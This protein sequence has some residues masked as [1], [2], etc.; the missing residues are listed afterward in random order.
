MARWLHKIRVMPFWFH[1]TEKQQ[2]ELYAIGRTV[3][4]HKKPITNCDGIIK[5]SK[6]QRWLA[7]DFVI[8]I[9]GELQWSRIP[10]YEKFGKLA[11]RLGL[12][13]GGDW[14]SDDII[15]P[16]ENDVYHVEHKGD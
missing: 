9:D 11:K 4:T 1:R 6:H 10:A 5:I 8:V 3:E 13:W 12:R 2:A 15:E 14:D 16:T 7:F